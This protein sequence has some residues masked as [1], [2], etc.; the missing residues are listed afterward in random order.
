MQDAPFTS[1]CL[2]M[3]KVSSAPQYEQ[4]T[5][6][7]AIDDEYSACQSGIMVWSEAIEKHMPL[8]LQHIS[9]MVGNIGN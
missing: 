8:V 5:S 3:K 9:S 7:N 2:R 1:D 6:G 4:G